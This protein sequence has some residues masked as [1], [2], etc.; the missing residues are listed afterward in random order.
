MTDY[1]CIRCGQVKQ[2]QDMHQTR[3]RVYGYCR[4]CL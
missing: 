2:L 1:K 4:K 3:L